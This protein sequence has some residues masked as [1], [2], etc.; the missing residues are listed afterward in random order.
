LITLTLK[1]LSRVSERFDKRV[2]FI[3]HIEQRRRYFRVWLATS[4]IIGL[5]HP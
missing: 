2:V 4:A 3:Q 5:K 1:A